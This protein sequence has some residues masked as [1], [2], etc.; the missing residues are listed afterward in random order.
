LQDRLDRFKTL[1]VKRAFRNQ[2]RWSRLPWPI[3][4]LAWWIGLNLSGDLRARKLGTFGLS[5]LGGQ[6]AVNR[7]HPTCL[8]T[9]LTFGP[10]D[11][12]GR[13]LVTILCDH[14]VADGA[15]IAR[16]ITDLEVIL[17]GPILREVQ[18]L[19]ESRY[20]LAG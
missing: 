14:R 13:C 1:P 16:A 2:E 10:I 5:T 15:C 7:F 8:T 3:R 9:S 20:A 12:D 17:N 18:G 4:R 11:A 6:G 19:N